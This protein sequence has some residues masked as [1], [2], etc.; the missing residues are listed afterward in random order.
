VNARPQ[1]QA[2]TRLL[3]SGNEAVARAV[4]EAGVRVAAAY[5]GTPATEMLETLTTY[6]D[7]VAQWGVNEKVSLEVAI[8]AAL[9]G[10]R[11][12]TALK[13][14]GLN[15]A[16]DA[17][18]SQ[19][20]AGV[21]AGLVIAAADDVG[22]SSSQNEQDSRFWGRFGHLP[23]LEPADAQEA[24]EMTLAAYEISEQFE[25]PV[26]LRMTTRVC[27]VKSLTT[28]GQRREAPAK[29]AFTHDPMRW[30]LVPATARRR[31]PVQ[32]ERD[33]AMAAASENSLLNF[34]AAGSDKRIGFVTSGPGYLNVREA[35]PNAPVFKLGFSYPPPIEKIRA[36][37]KGVE[38]IVVVE[39]TEKLLE[40]ELMAAGIACVGKAILPA[41]G[42]LAPEILAPAVAKLLGEPVP[43]RKATPAAQQ[44]FPRPPTMCVGCPHLGAYY[45]LARLRRQ[46]TIAGDIGCYT[47][48]ALHPWK[49]LDTTTCMGASLT[50][51]LGL[52]KGRAPE[53]QDKGIVA[54]I[55][56]STFLHMGMQG[57][58]NL[59]YNKGN[60]TVLILDNHTVGMTGGQDHPGTG[61][62]AYGMAA[63]RV[64]FPK[65]VEALGVNPERIKVVNP[66]LMPVL[67]KT[68]KEEI[69]IPEVSVIITNQPCVLIEDFERFA[70]YQVVEKDCTGCGNC[71][72]TGCPA[73]LVRKRETVTKN[74]RAQEL[75][76]VD[77][78]MSGCT[79]CGLCVETCGPDAIKR[80]APIAKGGHHHG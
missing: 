13:Q 57:L 5:P 15:V 17:L 67:F 28:V 33:K 49:A 64:D 8:G 70:P 47:L 59:T 74:N 4:W 35:F 80:M 42:E 77:I 71:L 52:D 54:V 40:T 32:V 3:L 38:R 48:G 1:P 29:G 61:K 53:D 2:G 79:G 51:A 34:A 50:M 23:I 46:V 41:S 25:T 30:V 31:Q 78:D 7:L 60:V 10:S 63:P 12:F 73:I 14:V 68:L 26:I 39:E 66:Y 19:T 62:D 27:H 58:L 76:F 16:A 69:A 36:F 18:M 75:A 55:G 37:A 45:T 72:N 21:R 11:S 56:D 20:L 65:L 9:A 44:V 43:V 6:P 24:Y 22:L